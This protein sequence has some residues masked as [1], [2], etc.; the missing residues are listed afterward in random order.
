MMNSPVLTNVLFFIMTIQTYARTFRLTAKTV[1]LL[2]VQKLCIS[3]ASLFLLIRYSTFIA[4]FQ[5]YILCFLPL[6]FKKNISILYAL[7]F[8]LNCS[9]CLCGSMRI[10]FQKQRTIFRYC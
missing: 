9:R 1:L 2:K 6:S 7:F 5:K 10:F 8:C 4:A 3:K